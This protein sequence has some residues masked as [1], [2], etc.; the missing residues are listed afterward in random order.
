MAHLPRFHRR[1]KEV[2]PP[3]LITSDL[4]G[5]ATTPATTST[6]TPPPGDLLPSG[7]PMR[8]LRGLS[9]FR[10]FQ[11][12]SGKRARD[13]PPASLPH[14]P[15]SLPVLAPDCADG[16]PVSPL[17]LKMDPAGDDAHKPAQLPQKPH[18]MPAFLDQTQEEILNK[19]S[20]L[21]W[22]E[23]NRLMQSVSNPSPDFRWA[24]VPGHQAKA[25]DRYMNVQPWHNNR[26]KL[27]VP[28]GRLDYINASP[29]MLAPSA[30]AV[31]CGGNSTC[32][33]DRYIAM[34]GPKQNSADHVWRMVVEQ[35]DSPC[36]MVMLTE[37]HEGHLEKCY[38]YFPRSPA[39]PPL[40][41]NERDEFGDGFRATVRCEAVEETPAGDA[42][43]LRRLVVRVH[44][45]SPSTSNKK[46]SSSASPTTKSHP[47]T[48]TS[49]TSSI[50]TP[51]D[52]SPASDLSTP[53][54][55]THQQQQATPAEPQQQPAIQEKT[56]YHFLY[57]KWP[58]FGVPALADLP[59]FF[60]LM[61]LSRA[62][63]AHPAN[64]RIV[65]CSAGVGRSGTFVALEH[66]ARELAAGAWEGWDER[67][68]AAGGLG[69]LDGVL[70]GGVAQ[71]EEAGERGREKDGSSG[72]GK[73][74]RSARSR[75]RGRGRGAGAAAD[76]APP[77]PALPRSAASSSASS[78]SN[79]PVSRTVGLEEDVV[80]E[81]VDRLREQ[82]RTMVQAE[83]QYLFI[84]QVLRKMWVDKYGNGSGGGG[85]GEEMEVDGLDDD[86][87]GHDYSAGGGGDGGEGE[88]TDGSAGEP[89]AK[90]LEVD[91]SF[92]G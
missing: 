37:T 50:T 40:E 55:P 15:A 63:N 80:F 16:R 18:K 64:P 51:I 87:D 12:A 24:R 36:V 59:S 23:R 69:G 57:K 10:V 78:G 86:H 70:P 79:S 34:Q 19:F 90:R 73:E 30:R 8:S 13:S 44:P 14:S 72:G 83:A 27:R 54:S 29:V 60:A 33:P 28:E 85:G 66:L 77:V 81:T 9:P 47:P 58:D 74:R 26:I 32:E 42:I 84:Y 20:E 25:L 76:A 68:A 71:E 45:P 48:P 11:R 52:S 31:E 82:R 39:D 21:V 61:R 56:V 89:A 22:R 3:T 62:R 1:K 65:H 75:S 53:P 46:S 43:E 67:V 49:S 2:A 91:P 4:Q 88:D 7:S 35:L 41:V 5:K 38:P 17:S 92:L 6:T